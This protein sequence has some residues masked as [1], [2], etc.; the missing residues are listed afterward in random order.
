MDRVHGGS[1]GPFP[2]LLLGHFP[3]GDLLA[4][5]RDGGREV[6]LRF[7]TQLLGAFFGIGH[8]LKQASIVTTLDSLCDPC[9]T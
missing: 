4:K 5:Q 1:T 2:L 8:L 9:E 6:F 3:H 7:A